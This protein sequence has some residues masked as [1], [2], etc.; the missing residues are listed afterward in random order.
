MNVENYAFMVQHG[1]LNWNRL[2][3]PSGTVSLKNKR[4][5]DE[6]LGQQ[7][8]KSVEESAQM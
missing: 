6:H 2:G 8:E 4:G 7:M 5:I 3:F 1:W